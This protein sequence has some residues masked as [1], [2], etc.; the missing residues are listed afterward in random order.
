MKA[1]NL[2][3]IIIT[4]LSVNACLGAEA[5]GVRTCSFNGGQRIQ[6]DLF[7]RANGFT[8]EWSDGPRM[9]YRNL[10]VGGDTQKFVDS[11]GGQWWWNSHR[12]GIGFNLYNPN[13]QNRISCYQ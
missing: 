2:V 11:L 8:I 1:R 4:F 9:S 12:D 3:L 13:N 6:V 10:N 5:Q 7:E